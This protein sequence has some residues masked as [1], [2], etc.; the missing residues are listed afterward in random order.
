MIT[1]IKQK[2]LIVGDED[3]IP[4]VVTRLARVGY[5]HAIGYLQGGIDAWKAEGKELDTIT[6]VSASEFASADAAD[7]SIQIVDVRKKSEYD[8]EHILNATNAPLDYIE[9]SM[10]KLDKWSLLCSLRW[11]V[12]VNDF[13]L[14]SQI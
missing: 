13:H 10:S 14:H 1:D 5:D 8:A 9:E 7:K 11:R 4:E 3:R 12:P 2:I 6:S